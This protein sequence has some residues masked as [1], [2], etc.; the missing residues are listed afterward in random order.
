MKRFATLSK[1]L[2][3]NPSIQLSVGGTE[4]NWDHFWAKFFRRERSVFTEVRAQTPIGLHK[5]Q[6]NAN[7]REIKARGNLFLFN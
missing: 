7:W 2:E 6:W 1:P 5:F 4:G 3:N